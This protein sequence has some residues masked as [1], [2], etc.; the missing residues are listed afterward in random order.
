[1]RGIHKLDGSPSCVHAAAAILELQWDVCTGRRS[2]AKESVF[3]SLPDLQAGNERSGMNRI[4]HPDWVKLS[5]ELNC[6]PNQNKKFFF[7]L[8]TISGIFKG[9]Q[10]RKFHLKTWKPIYTLS[11]NRDQWLTRNSTL[12]TKKTKKQKQNSNWRVTKTPSQIY[13]S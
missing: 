7:P 12:T 10:K 4:G 2:Q 5:V 6:A 13:S 9:L 1:M 8:H 11:T 3:G